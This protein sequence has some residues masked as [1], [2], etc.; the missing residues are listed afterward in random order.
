MAGTISGRCMFIWRLAPV[1]K[2]ELGVACMVA[3]AQAAGLSGVWIAQRRAHLATRT[4][5]WSSV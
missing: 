4:C 3:K 5:A 2:T 1:L